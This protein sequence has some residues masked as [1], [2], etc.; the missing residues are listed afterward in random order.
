VALVT[1]P[2]GRP[3]LEVRA[4]ARRTTSRL[5]ADRYRSVHW[6]PGGDVVWLEGEQALLA[7]DLASGRVGLAG[8]ALPGGAELLGFTA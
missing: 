8:P 4:A 1:G 2:A 5:P 6:S 3:Q 7:V